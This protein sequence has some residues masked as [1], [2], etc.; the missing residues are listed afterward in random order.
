MRAVL[1]ACTVEL[2]KWMF[3]RDACVRRIAECRLIDGHAW[4]IEGDATKTNTLSEG[5][6][7]ALGTSAGSVVFVSDFLGCVLQM[8]S[9]DGLDGLS[10]QLS[11]A[12]CSSYRPTAVRTRDCWRE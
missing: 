4:A 6:L 2:E 5:F 3:S 8:D 10:L 11:A 9:A 1:R 7:A 12:V